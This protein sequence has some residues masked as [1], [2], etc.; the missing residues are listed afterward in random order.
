MSVYVDDM[1]APFGR[2]KMSHLMADT[3]E[4][5]L[6]MADALGLRREWLQHGGTARE[7]FDVSMSKREQAIGFGAVALTARDLAR[8]RIRKRE[9][10]TP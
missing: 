8:M 10:V 4:E 7:H 3:T 9:G 5:L 1:F 2:M 6:A